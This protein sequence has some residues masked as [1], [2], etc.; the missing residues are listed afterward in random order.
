MKTKL[1]AQVG[2]TMDRAEKIKKLLNGE[3]EVTTS[4]SGGGSGGANAS[5]STMEK[6]KAGEQSTTA[7]S[8]TELEKLKKSLE[9]AIVTEKPNVRWCD[10][11]GLEQAKSLLQETVILPVKF[12]QLFTGKRKPWKGILLYQYICGIRIC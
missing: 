10:I 5:T 2:Q 7:E 12:P 3:L 9:G 6:P 4:T 1:K 11:A 8:D